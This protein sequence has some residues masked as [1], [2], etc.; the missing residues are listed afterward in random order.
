M[1]SVS[2]GNSV[3]LN[4]CWVLDS[5]C[6][7]HMCPRRDWFHSYCSDNFGSVL[8]GNDVSCKVIGMRSIKFK[9]FDGVIRTLENVRH[10]PELKK[11]LISLGTLD[12]NGYS[13]KSE[14]GALTVKKGAMIVMKGQ[15]LVGNIYKLLGDTVVGGVA[16]AE[17]ESDDTLLWHM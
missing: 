13:Y 6:S 8:M 11:N 2:T 10:V 4:D 3:K 5:A 1:L 17:S 14:C 12:T 16:T 7:Y 15:K 9:M